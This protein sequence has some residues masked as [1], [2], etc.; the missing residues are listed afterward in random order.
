M[1]EQS[2]YHKEHFV[3]VITLS[4]LELSKRYFHDSSEKSLVKISSGFI[5][6]PTFSWEQWYGAALCTN[7]LPMNMLHK[8]KQGVN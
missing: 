6:G 1:T 4:N 5:Q 3:T 7:E 2:L 8:I